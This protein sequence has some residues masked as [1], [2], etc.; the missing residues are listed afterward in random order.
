LFV[1]EQISGPFARWIH[2]HEFE[3]LGDG[4]T[5]L[6]DWIEYEMRGGRLVTA[7]LGWIIDIGLNRMFEHRH[8]VTRRYCE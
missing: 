4:R 7:C 3:D 5:R 1:D 8:R 6:T 2:R